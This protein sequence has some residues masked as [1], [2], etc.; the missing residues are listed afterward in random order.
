VP[1]KPCIRRRLPKEVFDRLEAG[2]SWNEPY[3]YTTGDVRAIATHVSHPPAPVSQ[4]EADLQQLSAARNH[5]P[6]PTKREARLAFWKNQAE[7]REQ[8]AA[9]WIQQTQQERRT[10]EERLARSS[11][12]KRIGKQTYIL[13]AS[14]PIVINFTKTT[15]ADLIGIF[16][17][18]I[19]ATALRLKPIVELEEHWSNVTPDQRRA[20]ESLV[21]KIQ[22]FSFDLESRAPAVTRVQWQSLDWG[23]KEVGKVSFAGLW[24]NYQEVLSRLVQISEQG[25]FDWL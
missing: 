15:T 16:K 21:D 10:L 18:K 22:S 5:A 17:P 23:L 11:L 24:R 2:R 3:R 9:V 1:R 13:I 12:A 14:K 19:T 20:F 4:L 25:Y 6:L 8:L 7:C